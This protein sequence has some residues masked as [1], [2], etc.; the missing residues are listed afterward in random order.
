VS[1]PLVYVIVLNYNGQRWLPACFEA[2]FKTTYP[3]FKTLLVDN[4]SN[5][6][7][8]ILMRQLFP[9]VEILPCEANLGFARG[10]NVG[11]RQALE[12]GA[13]YIV[14]LNPDTKVQAR[15]LTEIISVGEG[16]PQVGILGA[17][18]YN[19]D[20]C[21]FNGWTIT[22]L[23]N[24]L[25]EIDQPGN[26]RKWLPVEWV[27]GSCYAVK[28]EVFQRV[29][30]LDPLYH[31]FYEEI[32]FCR[33]AACL[34]YRTALVTNSRVHHQRGGNWESDS[35]TKSRRDYYCD[36][37]QFI[38]AITDPRRSLLQNFK[39]YVITLATKLK[40]SLNP[41]RFDWANLARL[42]LVQANLLTEWQG[43]YHKWQRDRQQA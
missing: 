28:R 20:D 33:R 22:A 8:V 10:N 4:N 42:F 11:I 17:V 3:N 16:E 39:W 21:S 27:E 2:L 32:D 9:Q 6:Q 15:W 30:L 26:G 29:G 36:R 40:E 23:P 25:A 5:D 7:S 19:Y 37:G 31:S 13:E 43:I 41:R 24:K 18:Q 14:L 34:G 1:L 12:A 35:E 38:F